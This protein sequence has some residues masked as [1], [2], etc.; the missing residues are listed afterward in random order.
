MILSVVSK[1]YKR[2]EFLIQPKQ[3]LSVVRHATS[4]VLYY[5]GVF[6]L[7]ATELVPILDKQPWALTPYFVFMQWSSDLQYDEDS[8]AVW[9][10][11]ESEQLD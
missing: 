3:W 4:L 11:L 5:L 6:S 1:V 2:F 9:T 8:W 10:V 7:K